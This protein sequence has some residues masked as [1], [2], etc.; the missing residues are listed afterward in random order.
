[1]VSFI[2]FNHFYFFSCWL[3]SWKWQ[4]IAV[5]SKEKKGFLS[6]NHVVP[7]VCY[8]HDSWFIDRMTW[9]F[10]G[11]FLNMITICNS[12][13]FF[14]NFFV[15]WR[16]ASLVHLLMCILL[17]V[18]ASGGMLNFF[19][20]HEYLSIW[21]RFLIIYPAPKLWCYLHFLPFFGGPL[22]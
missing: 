10:L 21:F 19:L 6:W 12:C 20:L 9:I 3:F 13:F 7:V 2:Y 18:L 16:D 4:D 15:F 11:L 17:I 8:T 1:M 14:L 22:T 5:S